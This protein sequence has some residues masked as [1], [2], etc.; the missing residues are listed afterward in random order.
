MKKTEESLGEK[1]AKLR[2]SRHFSQ[3]RLAEVADVPRRTLQNIESGETESPGIDNL[4]PIAVALE[5]SLGELV[6]EKKL[7]PRELIARAIESPESDDSLR[8]ASLLLQ[9]FEAAPP[10]LRAVVLAYL[11]QDFEIMRKYQ[12]EIAA[13][14]PKPK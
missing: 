10:R 11:F 8:V 9:Q 13:L 14:M 7:I 5:V 4:I 12:K 2:K 6:G 1:I 3:D